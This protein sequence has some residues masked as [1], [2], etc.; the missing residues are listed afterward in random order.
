MSRLLDTWYDVF[1]HARLGRILRSA[2]DYDLAYKAI[3][4]IVLPPL[5]AWV[6]Q[7]LINVSG[8]VSVTNEAIAG[9]LLSP[10]GFAFVL[11]AAT[12]TLTSFYTEQAGLMHI[13][14]A[15]GRGKLTHWQDALATALRA[16]PR[17]LHL[18]LWQTGILVLWLLPLAAV[19]AATYLNLLGDHDINF[20]LTQRPPAF[21][22]AVAIGAVLGLVAATVLLYFGTAWALAIPLCLYER[23]RGRAAL[24]RSA[25]LTRGHRWRAFRVVVLNLLLALAL[26][27]LVLWMADAGVGALLRL[28]TGVDALAAATALAVVLLIAVAAL[29]SYFLMTILAGSIIHLYLS[30]MEVDASSWFGPGFAREP[31]P[32]LSEALKARGRHVG[33]NVE[34]KYSGHDVQLA[35]RVV[36]TLRAE[37]CLDACIITSLSQ[38]GLARA[39][40]IAPELRIGQIVTAAIGKPRGLDVDLLSMNQAH[41]TPD[42]VHKNRSAGLET[43]VW[44][45][46][47]E[48]DMAPMLNCGVDNIITDYP[49]R[50]RKLMDQRAELSDPELLLLALGRRLRQ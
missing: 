44:T 40:Q 49:A 28:V 45:V 19:A 12:L 33:L 47:T 4:A 43:H 35:E 6:L 15:A 50:L 46:N 3:G 16:L 38:K 17:L 36:E 23:L 8:G 13:A 18:A 24:R 29:T 10:T 25:E 42:V 14:A 26:S 27:T 20:Y 21:L 32:T 41:V 34:P 7:R 9:F 48:A 5:T 11:V 30:L 22:A 39:R 1:A 31:L 2:L 37:G